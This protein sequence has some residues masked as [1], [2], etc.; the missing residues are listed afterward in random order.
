MKKKQKDES[1]IEAE[2]Y[3]KAAIACHNVIANKAKRLKEVRR[4]CK[5]NGLPDYTRQPDE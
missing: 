4:L 3:R 2:Q 5:E 1:A